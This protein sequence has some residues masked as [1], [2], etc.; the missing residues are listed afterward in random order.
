MALTRWAGP[1]AAQVLAQTL[2]AQ[3]RAAQERLLEVRVVVEEDLSQRRR[4]V[5]SAVLELMGS[6]LAAVRELACERGDA[7]GA[8]RV[9]R[10]VARFEELEEQGAAVVRAEGAHGWPRVP[11]NLLDA[12]AR[13][14]RMLLALWRLAA[15]VEASTSVIYKMRAAD[16]NAE[17]VRHAAAG[18]LDDLG[19][20]LRQLSPDTASRAS[21][22]SLHA[23]ATRLA[24]MVPALRIL[25]SG[26]VRAWHWQ[27]LAALAGAPPEALQ[28]ATYRLLEQFGL[29]EPAKQEAL[30]RV[31]EDVEAEYLLE[32]SLDKMREQWDSAAVPLRALEA[33]GTFYVASIGEARSLLG[34]QLA[35]LDAIQVPL[36]PPRLLPLPRCEPFLW[37]SRLLAVN[38]CRPLVVNGWRSR[39]LAV[40]G[41]SRLLAVNGCRPQATEDARH[42]AASRAWREQLSAMEGLLEALWDAP[43][44]PPPYCCPYPCPYCALTP[45]LPTVAPTRVPTVHSL[46]P[47]LL[48][49]LP[50]PLL[51]TH[52][53]PPSQVGRAEG[54]PPRPPLLR[55]AAGGRPAHL[56]APPRPLPLPPPLRRGL[57]LRG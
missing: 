39:L 16:I 49:P 38:G 44:P 8:A 55:R 42:A 36:P 9:E 3:L 25:G 4:G 18:W 34:D 19:A 57:T 20:M 17:R 33:S 10:L 35:R 41:C 51:Y 45:S 27:R 48:L 24:G 56:L 37:C 21:T 53:L 28:G 47:S 6:E 32:E 13:E 40:N 12:A 31:H 7:E 2:P 23:R 14:A 30:A 5:Q 29:H 26:K 43:P 46:T 15:R 54:L 11:I 1:C 22:E 50:V 52:S